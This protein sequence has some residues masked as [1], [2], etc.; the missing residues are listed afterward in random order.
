MTLNKAFLFTVVYF[1]PLL[2][3]K[4]GFTL[5]TSFDLFV[6]NNSTELFMCLQK[7]VAFSLN[8][9]KFFVTSLKEEKDPEDHNI[10]NRP[11]ERPTDSSTEISI[12]NINDYF[13]FQ[14]ETNTGKSQD[15]YIESYSSNYKI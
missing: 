10:T 15:G 13:S 4:D 3:N 11:K 6:R 14:S 12:H 7:V 9:F 1:I 5:Q 8:F 2:R